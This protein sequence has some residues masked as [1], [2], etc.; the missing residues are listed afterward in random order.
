MI[1]DTES[2]MWDTLMEEYGVSEE[3]LH[4][5]TDVAGYSERTL[6][7]VL[8]SVAGEREFSWQLDEDEDE[9][10]YFVRVISDGELAYGPAAYSDYTAALA[11]YRD[12]INSFPGYTVQVYDGADYVL[13]ESSDESPANQF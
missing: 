11:R 10:V 2:R 8:Y 12:L 6:L 7:D 5:V 3:T 13:A 1:D 4:I 9:D